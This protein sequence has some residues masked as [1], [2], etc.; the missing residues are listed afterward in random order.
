MST[1]EVPSEFCCPHCRAAYFECETDWRGVCV[2]RPA[3]EIHDQLD[4]AA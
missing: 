1:T 4:D 3:A 2:Q